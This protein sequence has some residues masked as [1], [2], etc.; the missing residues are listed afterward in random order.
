MGIVIKNGT[1]IDGTRGSRFVGD[2]LIEDDEI[3]EIGKIDSSNLN[4]MVINANGKIV[5]PG[6]IDTHSHSDLEILKNPFIEPKIRQGI[7]TEILGQ[8][9]ISMAP[10]PLEYIE[11]WKKNISG[12]NGA[13]EEINWN[14]RDTEGYFNEIKKKGLTINEGYLVPHGNIRMEGMGLKDEKAGKEALEKMKL[15]LRRELEAGAVGLSTGLIYIPCAYADEEE[16][17]ELCKV[18]KDYNRPLVIH[19]RSEANDII[20]SIKS[21]LEIAKETGVSVHFSHFK[22]CGKNNWH[23]I[24]EVMALLDNAK[25]EGLQVSFDQYPY[26]A[27]STMLSVI[28]PPWVHS[29]GTIK[30]LE[31]LQDNEI[32]K[33]VENEIKEINCIWDN[34]VEFAGVEG[35]FIT[36]VDSEKNRFVIGKSLSEIGQILGKDPIGVAIDLIIEEQNAVGMIDYYGNEEHVIRLMKREE[37]NLCTDGLLGGTPHPRVY[38]SFPRFISKYVR[39]L[40]IMT[41][42]EAIYKITEKPAKVFNLSKR[43]NIKIGYKADI[44]IFDFNTIEDKGDYMNPRVFP[45]GIDYVIVNG[46]I[47]CGEGKYQNKDAGNLI[48]L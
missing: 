31:K 38:G 15:V 22:I 5:S 19:Q 44:V 46:K 3:K 40:S 17:L 18:L 27:G 25:D 9:G 23:K 32:R 34:F 41:L 28:L 12:L 43:G 39:D 21:V 48:K 36:S 26:T 13:S 33:K 16:V 35:I 47:V 6:F 1:I 45:E 24:D 7:T 42:E 14:F 30:M 20:E 11:D 8:D 2:I 29:G 4:H 10:L 37:Q